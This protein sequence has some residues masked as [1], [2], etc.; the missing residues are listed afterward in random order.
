M[1]R[2]I[3]NINANTETFQIWLDRTNEALD[4]L[5]ETVTLKSNTAGDTTAGNGFVVGILGANTLTATQIRG[6]NVASSD[7]ITFVSNTNFATSQVNAVANVYVQGAN[8]TFNSN[9]TV[10]AIK[11]ASNGTST[12]TTVGGTNL[13]VTANTRFDSDINLFGNLVID[14][15]LTGN[16]EITGNSVFTTTVVYSSNV[17][18]QAGLI[19][20][21]GS[22]G[23]ANQALLS[24]GSAVYWGTLISGGG[25]YKGSNGAIGVETNKENIFRVNANTLT[26]S[27]TFNAGEN[28]SAAGPITVAD[29]E[30]ITIA[31]GARVTIV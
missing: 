31:T 18:F 28:A 4:V 30:S 8:L 20:A 25:Y 27:L 24:N 15:T 10:T 16:V 13:R 17:E 6:G 23:T 22:I 14:G 19:D 11:V 9:S 26:T 2:T 3:T 29:G 1:S 7:Y 12:N 5:E 21:N